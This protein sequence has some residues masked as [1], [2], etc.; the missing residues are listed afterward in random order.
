MD[1]QA[2]ILYWPYALVGLILLAFVAGVV[3]LT[4]FSHKA[5]VKALAGSIKALTTTLKGARK[6]LFHRETLFW[7]VNITFMAYS[8]YHAAPFYAGVSV[9]I[10]GMEWFSQYVGITA[11]LVLDALVIVFQSAR[12]RA[13]YK[14]D[15]KRAKM[16]MWYIFACCGMNTVANLYTNYQ[17][18]DASAYTNFW[19]FALNAAPVFLSLFPLFIMF[20]SSALDEMSS[21]SALDSLDVKQ[22]RIDEEKRVGLVEAQAAFQEREINADRRLIELE[23]TRRE[24]DRLRRGKAPKEHRVSRLKAWLYH[25]PVQQDYEKAVA[26]MA[27]EMAENH[28]KSIA[29]I[30]ANYDAQI[31]DLTS[32]IQTLNTTISAMILSKQSRRQ[33][34]A[35]PVVP[36]NTFVTVPVTQPSTVASTEERHTDPQ[37]NVAKIDGENDARSDGASDANNQRRRMTL[38]PGR[39]SSSDGLRR[40]MQRILA[41][42][43]DTKSSVLGQKLN[44]SESYARQLRGQIKQEVVQVS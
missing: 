44:I 28:Q 31:R 23:K 10:L 42:N 38:L 20:M 9:N 11:P 13:G 4:A 22:F 24:N 41:K 33:N 34:V 26:K 37:L 12:K 14:H 6:R 27:Q 16:Y 35:T 21:S 17:H 19:S 39:K 40:K 5:L 2:L 29:D 15:R 25:I 3:T 36:I 8:A 1:L 30:S 7:V 32:Q 18:F 43:P